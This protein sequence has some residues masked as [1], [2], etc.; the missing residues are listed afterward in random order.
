MIVIVYHYHLSALI[1]MVAWNWETIRETSLQVSS[2]AKTKHN[3]PFPQLPGQRVGT[4]LFEWKKSSYL[5]S[6]DYFSRYIEIDKLPDETGSAVINHTK[7]IF[8]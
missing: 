4:D 3:W 8:A 6:V 5:L 2:A 1:S 7:S